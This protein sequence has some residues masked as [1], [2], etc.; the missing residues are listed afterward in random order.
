M[1][2]R[3]EAKKNVPSEVEMKMA[4]ETTGRAIWKDGELAVVVGLD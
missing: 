4:L 3:V 1:K 2:K